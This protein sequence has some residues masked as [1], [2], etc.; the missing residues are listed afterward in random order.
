M[1]RRPHNVFDIFAMEDASDFD[2]PESV[3]SNISTLGDVFSENET[4]YAL[5]VVQNMFYDMIFSS[6]GAYAAT[7]SP[8]PQLAEEDVRKVEEVESSKEPAAMNES[9][10]L[11][12]E[13]GDNEDGRDG[14]DGEDG[15]SASIAN[16][17]KVTTIENIE[18][19]VDAVDAAD[20]AVAIVD[21]IVD[22]GA[23]SDAGTGADAGTDT[24]GDA[25]VVIDATGA[26]INE[27]VNEELDAEL[28]E[29]LGGKLNENPGEE[30]KEEIAEKTTED[31]AK[32]INA[33]ADEEVKLSA[34]HAVADLAKE[35]QKYDDIFVE[36]L[37]LGNPYTPAVPRPSARYGL[38][39]TASSGRGRRK[40]IGG[41]RAKP[42]KPAKRREQRA[43]RGGEKVEGAQ[44]QP[45][46]QE[47]SSTSQSV[48]VQREPPELLEPADPAESAESPE[49]VHPAE[50][51]ELPEPAEK[52]G[53]TP[54]QTHSPS[55]LS[56]H[57]TDSEEHL[58]V[59][60]EPLGQ[61]EIAESAL[62]LQTFENQEEPGSLRTPHDQDDQDGQ[63]EQE[64]QE[65]QEILEPPNDTVSS[66]TT[67]SNSPI[68][69]PTVS[70]EFPPSQP[71]RDPVDM[72][73]AI[74]VATVS[75]SPHSP[76]DSFQESSSPSTSLADELSSSFQLVVEDQ[77]SPELNAPARSSDLSV[78]GDDLT[79]QPKPSRLPYEG[80][81]TPGPAPRPLPASC[82]PRAARRIELVKEDTEPIP[83]LDEDLADTQ[84]A[85][86]L[87]PVQVDARASG[88][89]DTSPLPAVLGCKTP[90]Q[91]CPLPRPPEGERAPVRA[92][93]PRPR[94]DD[95]PR[96]ALEGIYRACLALASPG[97]SP[98]PSVEDEASALLKRAAG[99]LGLFSNAPL[100]MVVQSLI[101]AMRRRLPDLPVQP[102]GEGRVD[103]AS[104]LAT[105]RESLHALCSDAYSRQSRRY[106]EFLRIPLSEP[107]GESM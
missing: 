85:F 56:S 48:D 21:A 47:E 84:P 66:D 81:P 5:F 35:K 19:A 62:P 12:K 14:E 10:S 45:D 97:R 52:A 103:P 93:P 40:S 30:I 89:R 82:R 3:F 27:E 92:R 15:D 9:E 86:E 55:P 80:L 53:P 29:K 74:P 96:P 34:A 50:L 61:A 63:E 71:D 91:Q 44:S 88:E 22:N 70:T 75:A 98:D 8:R 57:V 65:G 100:G 51:E 105:L 24:P 73:V 49:P 79:R 67:T 64:E 2:V 59:R 101:R 28:G 87:T 83:G 20:T 42:R 31:A 16:I 1:P 72:S 25:A 17:K 76:S 41:T 99:I 23:A 54:D 18:N 46:A 11:G 90:A 58:E 38:S 26:E 102:Q 6:F 77:Q 37:F 69:P 43:E 60:A 104:S 39:R 106:G 94:L 68:I 33:D 4:G 36:E 78:D 7:I 13:E 95:F 107:R 32:E